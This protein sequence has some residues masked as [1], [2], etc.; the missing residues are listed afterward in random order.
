[1]L[2]LAWQRLT[3][4]YKVSSFVSFANKAGP[5]DKTMNSED[6]LMTEFDPLHLSDKI[7]PIYGHL[8]YTM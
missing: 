3:P 1:M 2:K 8:N 6:Q 4:L 5:L 7:M